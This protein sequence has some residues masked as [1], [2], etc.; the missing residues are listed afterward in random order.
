MSKY[1]EIKNETDWRVRKK[2]HKN[3]HTTTHNIQQTA[4]STKQI[5]HNIDKNN[6]SCMRNNNK[7]KAEACVGVVT[8]SRDKCT[9]YS[10]C[11]ACRALLHFDNIT[12]HR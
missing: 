12:H 5:Q 6:Y 11:P 10:K 9:E 8:N 4:H 2:Q 7:N 1:N 3:I